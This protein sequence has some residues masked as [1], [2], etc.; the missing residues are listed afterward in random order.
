MAGPAIDRDWAAVV[1]TTPAWCTVKK[2]SRWNVFLIQC[3][4]ALD[5]AVGGSTDVR[6]QLGDLVFEL[7]DV[8]AALV[9]CSQMS[10][11]KGVLVHGAFSIV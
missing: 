8:H 10:G 2:R 3:L 5:L 9:G 11:G 7:L 6:R 4:I 1:G